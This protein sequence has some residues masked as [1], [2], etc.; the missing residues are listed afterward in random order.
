MS[1][2]NLAH[3][4]KHQKQ[5][6][7]DGKVEQRRQSISRGGSPMVVERKFADAPNIPFP[8]AKDTKLG[9]ESAKIPGVEEKQRNAN[10][11]PGT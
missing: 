11:F 5:P 6:K 3:G 2:N 8:V 1:G 9:K 7:D 10:Q 4:L